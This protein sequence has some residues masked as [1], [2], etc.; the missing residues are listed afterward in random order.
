MLPVSIYGSECEL[1]KSPCLFLRLWSG[2]SVWQQLFR[3]SYSQ[4][5]LLQEQ[6]YE[7][8]IM[9]LW[10]TFQQ[11]HYDSNDFLRVAVKS[12]VRFS[13]NVSFQI[14]LFSVLFGLHTSSCL[15]V[16]V[17]YNKS[18]DCDNNSCL[19][20]FYPGSFILYVKEKE[21]EADHSFRI[22]SGKT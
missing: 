9:S 21:T 13:V 12:C 17:L 15:D 20:P 18:V 14:R 1:Y 6:M 2:S 4:Q 11:L 5:Q 16:C 7:I 19:P 10:I 3:V 8:F 22:F